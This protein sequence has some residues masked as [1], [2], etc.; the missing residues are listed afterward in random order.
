M[1][2]DPAQVSVNHASF[3]VHLA[4]PPRPPS[5]QRAGLPAPSLTAPS[6]TAQSPAVPSL[7]AP[8]RSA[9]AAGPSDETAPLPVV[10]APG[11]PHPG[12]Y[13][14]SPAVPVGPAVSRG[15]RVLRVG[16][17]GFGDAEATRLLPTVPVGGGTR[18]LPRVREARAPHRVTV[19]GPRSPYPPG[20][21]GPLAAGPGGPA[22]SPEPIPRSWHPHRRRNPGIVLLPLRIFLGGI[23]VYAGMG[24]LCD[25]VYFDGGE[26]GSMVQWLSSLHPWAAAEPLHDFA[27]AH[28]V[29]S[30]LTIAFTQ[31]VVGTLSVLGLWQRA[32]AAVGMLLSAALLLTVSWRNVPVYDAPDIVYFAA[33]SP[34]LIAGAPYFSLDARLARD[35]WRRL[36][37]HTSVYQLR[38]WALRRGAVVATVVTGL[39]LLVGSLLG[40]A[41]RAGTFRTE[42]PEPSPPPTNHLPGSPLPPQE[43]PSP[44]GG[45]RSSH[46]S[47]T[48]PGSTSPSAAAPSRSPRGTTPP[49]SRRT[50][51]APAGTEAGTGGA[52][53]RAPSQGG[54][55][56][57]PQPAVPTHP[58]PALPSP[59]V[60]GGEGGSGGNEGGG[61]LGG[62]LGGGLL[63]ME[64]VRKPRDGGAGSA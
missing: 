1:P 17:G 10:P 9:P 12:E 22:P 15:A 2:S 53:R 34:L 23:C 19:I 4:R 36:G 37:P 25:P 63:G 39:T 41:V 21:P 44:S 48:R 49:P 57:T 30:G 16:R 59:P 46:P 43:S 32:A 24:K 38:C 62:I 64:S 58:Q 20:R 29:G 18:L 47:W 35:A 56:T 52:T 3:R 11:R 42:L 13:A 31:I 55:A 6:P 8:S 51:P 14:R 40:G 7:P 60:G 28:P 33:W 5:W 54:P 26:R 50:P 45:A 27:L 61:A